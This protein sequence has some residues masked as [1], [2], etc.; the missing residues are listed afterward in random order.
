MCLLFQATAS[1]LDK[2][3]PPRL[4]QSPQLDPS[5]ALWETSF[6]AFRVKMSSRLGRDET[7]C[8]SSRATPPRLYHPKGEGCQCDPYQ[9]LWYTALSG[10][11]MKTSS[12]C[13]PQL[14]TLGLPTAVPPILY[15]PDHSFPF[16]ALW[17]TVLSIPRANRS[18]LL[19]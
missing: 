4:S 5:Q 15:Q 18:N 1:G 13:G 6:S 3:T 14:T 2:V 7:A 11:R 19:V 17:Y 9:P 16:H 10:P 8:M 12:L